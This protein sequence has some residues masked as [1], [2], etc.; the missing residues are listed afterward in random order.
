[1]IEAGYGPGFTLEVFSEDGIEREVRLEDFYGHGAPEPGV[2]GFVN[3]A[4]A[5]GA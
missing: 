4:H 2:A 5:T 3:L 1:M